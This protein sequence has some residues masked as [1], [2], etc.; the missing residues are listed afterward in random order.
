MFGIS[1]V[2]TSS[3][4]VEYIL[5]FGNASNHPHHFPEDKGATV[6]TGKFL[7]LYD[8]MMTTVFSYGNTEDHG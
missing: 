8:F 7:L 2:K 5:Y 6:E 3:Q 4:H 1:Q